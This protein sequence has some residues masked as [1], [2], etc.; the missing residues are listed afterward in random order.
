MALKQKFEANF[1]N[2]MNDLHGKNNSS[3]R[4]LTD[5]ATSLTSASRQHPFKM[6]YNDYIKQEMAK[7][8]YSKSVGGGM[9]AQRND[10]NNKFGFLD[11]QLD[12][13]HGHG[14]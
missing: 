13:D 9:T 10:Q 11:T 8:E 7:E 12:D 5:G 14:V 6:S 4:G 1:E 3:Q 2:F